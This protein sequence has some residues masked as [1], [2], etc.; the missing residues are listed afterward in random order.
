MN[1]FEDAPR[2]TGR[3]YC[4]CVRGQ[5]LVLNASPWRCPLTQM[6]RACGMADGDHEHDETAGNAVGKAK[7]ATSALRPCHYDVLSLRDKA[8]TATLAGEAIDQQNS[9]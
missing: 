7:S 6:N 2:R 5:A 9:V 3:S 4:R 8:G 1:L